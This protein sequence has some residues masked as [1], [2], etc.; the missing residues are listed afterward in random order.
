MQLR[1]SS[2]ESNIMQAIAEH[3]QRIEELKEK[4]IPVINTKIRE[5]RL[6]RGKLNQLT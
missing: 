3:K 6:K 2:I 1:F 4:C 5:E